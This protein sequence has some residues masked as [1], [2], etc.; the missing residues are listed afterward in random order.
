MKLLCK[1]FGHKWASK[2]QWIPSFDAIIVEKVIVHHK[3][4]RCGA[5]KQK[6]WF[7]YKKL[8]P[9]DYWGESEFLESFKNY[10][11]IKTQERKKIVQSK[12]E[13][14]DKNIGYKANYWLVNGKNINL[15]DKD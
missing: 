8:M 11:L 1:I 5:K 7:N 3:C 13:Q 9:K 6:T 14:L 2:A 15:K 12:L 4:D 10:M